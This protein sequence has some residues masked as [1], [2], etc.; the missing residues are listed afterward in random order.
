MKHW[1]ITKLSVLITTLITT[2]IF[3]SVVADERSG[4]EIVG[5]AGKYYY[6]TLSLD[7]ASMKALGIGYRFDNNWQV[8]L[9]KGDPDTYTI[10]GNMAI[11]VDWTALRALYYFDQDSWSP[12]V[13][14][15]M[16]AM[17]VFSGETQAV[18]GLGVKVKMS[19]RTFWRLEGNYHSNEGENSILALLGY[20]FGGTK[21]AVVKPKDSDGDGVMDNTD[22]CPRTPAGDTVDD[23]GCTSK[24]VVTENDSDND[25]VIDKL[26]KCPNTPANALVNSDGCQKELSKTVSVHLKINFDTNKDTVKAE[27][28]SEVERVANFMTQYASTSVVI[29]GHSDS[30]GKATYN[31]KLSSRRAKSVANLLIGKYAITAGRVA[32]QGF[33]E[34]KP[35][36][37]NNTAEGRSKNRR[38]VAVIKQNVTEKQWKTN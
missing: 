10:P 17:D 25:G 5:G 11:N 19:D 34:T 16:D 24:V 7:N 12:Y 31:E 2:F 37:D 3:S 8:E 13:S 4:L 38:V 33:G 18:I 28:Y 35:I 36:T 9:I 26:D 22:A 21:P 27:Y 20:E 1:R 14:V 29:E 6:N 15:G 32:S 30:I 23:I